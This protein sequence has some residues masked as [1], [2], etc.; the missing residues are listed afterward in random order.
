[1]PPC[2]VGRR[3]RPL[4]SGGGHRKVQGHD[5]DEADV[6]EE[7]ASGLAPLASVKGR[8]PQRC[9]STGAQ[10]ER[11]LGRSMSSRLLER[12]RSMNDGRLVDK[13]NNLDKII[14]KVGYDETL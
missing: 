3:L 2:A 11:Q 6:D 4:A 8:P 13:F 12:V 10:G 1:M 5:Q 7:A 9:Y 14:A